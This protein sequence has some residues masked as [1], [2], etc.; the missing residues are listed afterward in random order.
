MNYQ[1]LVLVI[2]LVI[3]SVN[4]YRYRYR[5]RYYSLGL[6]TLSYLRRKYDTGH[7][8]PTPSRPD[9]K[10]GT[11]RDVV[12]GDKLKTKSL[13]KYNHVYSKC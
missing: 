13:A 11:L 1:V 4:R 3:V 6:R 7:R 5:Y 2:V 10:S 9:P 12:R 8:R